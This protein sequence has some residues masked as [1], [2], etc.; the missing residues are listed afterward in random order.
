MAG[1]ILTPTALWKDFSVCQDFNFSIVSEQKDGDVILTY[2]YINGRRVGDSFVKIY[3]VL[4]KTIQQSVG[5]AILAVNDFGATD[6][7]T[8]ITDL[9]KKGYTVMSIDLE[10][11]TDKTEFFTVYPDKID[12]ANY[13]KAKENLYE[14]KKD[15]S[16]SC[17]YEWA[18]ALRYALSYLKSRPEVTKVGGFGIGQ[19]ATALWEVAGSSTDLDCVV[20]AL[21]TGWTLY[22]GTE[23]FGTVIEPQFTDSMYKFV[24]GIE[25]QTYAMHVTCPTLVLSTTNS[26]DYDVDRAYDTIEKI[27]KDVYRAIHYSVGYRECVNTHGY[28]TALVFLDNCLIKENSKA[29]GLPGEIDIKCD[30]VDG[31][32]KVTVLADQNNLTELALFSSEEIT[33]SKIRNYEKHL[34][35][36]VTEEGREF[37]YC[38]FN[39]SGI[40]IFFAQA[41]YKNGFKIGSKVIAKKFT[42]EEVEFSYKNN[43]LFSSRI[44]NQQIV[45]APLDQGT[46]EFAGVN[47]TEHKI[48][49]LKKGP[50]GINGVYSSAGLITFKMNA[51][52]DKPQEQAMLMFDVY[53]KQSCQM[54]VILI[55]DYYG[56]KIK[57]LAKANLVG[58]E[59]WQN[60]KLELSKFKTAEGR[61]IRSLDKIQ[62]LA[63][64]VDSNDYLIN[65]VLW[66]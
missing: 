28:R 24:A 16:L 2:F 14:I 38:P 49:R 9:A 34:D 1:A 42:Q 21:N 46:E 53:S 31:K 8:L 26:K 6:S 15:A 59:L 4:A 7:L 17:W 50:M 48:V 47:T 43:V 23:K 57:Y 61:G 60:V 64:K 66:V 5:P 54:D 27:N 37:T 44:E 55:W 40:A 35:S 19:G 41:T 20:F 22:R 36:K 25:P 3:G 63:F 65:N 33:D 58:G 39:Q 62:A 12:Y 32:I 18:C 51:K 13:E 52:K 11:K 45:F 56:E 29:E 30:L 10:G